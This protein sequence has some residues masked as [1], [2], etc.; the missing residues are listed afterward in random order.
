VY[1]SYWFVLEPPQAHAFYVLSPI[2]FMFAA[3][4][5][6]MVDSPR[7]RRIA[8]GVLVLNIAF[9][10][11]LAWTQAPELS[12]YRNRDVVAT[13]VRLKEPEMFAHRRDFA[14]GGG[15]SVLSDPSRPYDPTRDFQVLASAYRAGPLQSQHWTITV[16]NRSDAVAFRDPLYI[17]TYFDDRDGVVE[18]RHERL[19]DIFQPGEK[20][21]IELNDG[22][23]R[24][25]FTKATLRI[26][27]AE[28]LLP[29]PKE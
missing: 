9:H 5:W 15:P 28:A 7:A 26:V 17:A 18:E 21:T 13:A 14:I 11:G 4:W 22:V 25:P 1:V 8:A 24:A 10:A 3:F 27:A 2:A 29:A 12:L 20:R 6:T 19:K 23:V 16:E